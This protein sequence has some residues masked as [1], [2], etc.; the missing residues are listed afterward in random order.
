[1]IEGWGNRR[2]TGRYEMLSRRA[3]SVSG[4]AGGLITTYATGVTGIEGR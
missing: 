1:M 4:F 2:I 3:F